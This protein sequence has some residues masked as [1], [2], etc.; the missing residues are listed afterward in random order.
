VVIAEIPG[1]PKTGCF[2]SSLE[3]VLAEVNLM[4]VRIQSRVKR[5]RQSDSL[6]EPDQ[7]KGLYISDREIEAILEEPGG[8]RLGCSLRDNDYRSKAVEAP[9]KQ[10]E[11]EIAACKK[12]ASAMV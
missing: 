6:K 3:H 9:F 11:D 7:F 1:G 12:A 2:E 5:L 8:L 4:A 10:L